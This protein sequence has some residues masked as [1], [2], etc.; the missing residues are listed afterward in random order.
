MKL[1]SDKSIELFEMLE[2]WLGLK[3]NSFIM[4]VIKKLEDTYPDKVNELAIYA[5]GR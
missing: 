5:E 1:A 3:Y 2:E 4:A